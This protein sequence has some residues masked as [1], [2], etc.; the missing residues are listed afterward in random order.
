MNRL[1]SI[2]LGILHL[3]PIALV[4]VA[5]GAYLLARTR[6]GYE[7]FGTHWIAFGS[8]GPPGAAT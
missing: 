3:W 4:V 5:I 1:A 2:G 6:W 8:A 7:T